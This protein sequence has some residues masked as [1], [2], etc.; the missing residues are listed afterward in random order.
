MCK[1]INVCKTLL[2]IRWTIL[3]WRNPTNESSKHCCDYLPPSE[4]WAKYFWLYLGCILMSGQAMSPS[5]FPDLGAITPNIC[6]VCENQ[7]LRRAWYRDNLDS[8]RSHTFVHSAFEV[9][10]SHISVATYVICA[11]VFPLFQISRLFRCLK[12]QE[13][14]KTNYGSAPKIL[15]NAGSRQYWC[16]GTTGIEK[17]SLSGCKTLYWYSKSPSRNVV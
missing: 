13:A 14:G 16:C 4:L 11:Q 5:A 15:G 8:G 2:T 10:K 9:H 12:G 7:L 6:L 17:L 1:F 3:T